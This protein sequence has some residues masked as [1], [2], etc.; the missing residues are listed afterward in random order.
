VLVIPHRHITCTDDLAPGDDAL[1]GKLIRTG[2]EIAKREG[3][4][5]GT[6][7]RGY[8]LVLNAGP[9]AG[10]SV[11]HVHLHVLGGRRLAWPP[12]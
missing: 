2:V 9:D 1:V 11:F 6:S 8:R 7:E 10:Y 4:A 3:H 5:C 12:G